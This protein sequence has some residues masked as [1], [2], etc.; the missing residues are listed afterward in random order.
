V[1][2]AFNV[3]VPTFRVAQSVCVIALGTVLS[4]LSAPTL[5]IP[6]L[7]FVLGA[8]I[9]E[10]LRLVL[11]QNLLVNSDFSVL[12]GQYFLAPVASGALLT[13]AALIEIPKAQEIYIGAADASHNLAEL[14][15]GEFNLKDAMGPLEAIAHRPHLFLAASLV[16]VLVNYL[17][18]LVIREVGSLTLK[19]LGTVRNVGLV[20]Y[21]SFFLGE[22][23]AP[24]QYLGYTVSLAAFIAYTH[25]KSHV[26]S[27][28]SRFALTTDENERPDVDR[29]ALL[30]SSRGRS[31]S[32]ESEA[33]DFDSAPDSPRH[34][35]SNSTVDFYFPKLDALAKSLESDLMPEILMNGQMPS[36][37]LTSSSSKQGSRAGSDEFFDLGSV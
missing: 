32:W 29:E 35:F 25:F 28:P 6:G 12:E 1:L 2:W 4:T 5:S 31:L 20:L 3:E 11:T 22:R 8:E 10:A 13:L 23:L 14:E 26:P 18:Y 21:G 34:L 7:L 33:S 17:G 9:G 16:G 15:G 36:G 37:S 30:S 19:I 27:G 24:M